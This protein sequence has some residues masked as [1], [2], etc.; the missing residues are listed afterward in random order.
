MPAG[1]VQGIAID[2]QNYSTQLISLLQNK[3]NQAKYDLKSSQT[4]YNQVAA[5]AADKSSV[6]VSEELIK[7]YN[8]NTSRQVATQALKYIFEMREAIL[9]IA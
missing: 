5:L 6:K 3:A 2:A 4:T 1:D 9:R 7:M 8:T